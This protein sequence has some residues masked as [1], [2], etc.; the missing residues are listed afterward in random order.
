[1]SFESY[2]ANQ[3]QKDL[4][5]L[6]LTPVRDRQGREDL[7]FGISYWADIDTDL[8]RVAP[9]NRIHFLLALFTMVTVD[10]NMH[11]H[12]R[13]YYDDYREIVRLPKF[14]PT[15]GPEHNNPKYILITAEQRGHL[16]ENDLTPGLLDEAV[17]LLKQDCAGFF[18]KAGLPIKVDD[19]LRS[20]MTDK[21]FQEEPG[22]RETAY[23]AVRERL[24]REVGL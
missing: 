8:A 6:K 16:S 17:E 12:Y 23:G 11:A 18:A 3:F 24:R 7:F 2:L 21:A 4:G 13:E 5:K 19:F 22:A 10:E 9:G 1:M 20:M 15:I 14:G